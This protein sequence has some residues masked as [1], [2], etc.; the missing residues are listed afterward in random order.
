[1][2]MAGN[3]KV[4]DSDAAFQ[5]ELLA[6]GTKLVVVDFFAVWCGPCQR[7]S[8][9]FEQLAAKY[10]RAI[11]LK[12]DV[13]IC[14][15]TGTSIGVSA[16]P[17]F[18]FYRNKTKLDALRGADPVELEERIKKWYGGQGDE[19]DEDTVVKGH[20]DLTTF[21]MKSGCECLNESNEYPLDGAL[22]GKD[23]YLESD[24]DEQLLILMT[25]N[26]LIKLHSIRLRGPA[27]QG[28]KT[29]KLFI[30]QPK[31]LDFDS[32]ESM[33]AVQTLELTPEDVEGGIV[34]PLLYVKFQNVSSI[35]VFIKNNHTGAETT[36][37][38]QLTFYGSPVSATNMADFKRVAGKKGEAH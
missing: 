30:N 23:G 27:D 8:P 28:P 12:V 10:P 6:A 5:P 31:S 13:D 17:T 38:D 9:V 1:M 21:F 32:A 26:Q 20:M 3:Y 34:I 22:S 25:F 36:R 29:V 33:G 11:F 14:R 15:D 16:L 4:V 2:E 18:V 19:E 37:I 35:T 7:I 24:C